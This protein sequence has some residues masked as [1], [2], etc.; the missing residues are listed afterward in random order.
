MAVS[1]AIKEGRLVKCV[2]RDEHGRPKIADPELADRE[3]D[4]NTDR[5]R[6]PGRV[7]NPPPPPPPGVAPAPAPPDDDPESFQ[8]AHIRHELAKAEIAE[9]KLAEI[10]GELIPAADVRR[11]IVDVFTA[12]KTRLLGLPTQI[13]QAIPELTVEQVAIV[14]AL[15]R[16]ALTELADGDVE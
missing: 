6:S 4:Q 8:A 10:K 13:R 1:L 14:E 12:S 16:E 3:W 9:V 7:F 11:R 2:T 5:T 15:V